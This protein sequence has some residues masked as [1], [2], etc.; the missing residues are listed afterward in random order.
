MLQGNLFLLTCKIITVRLFDTGPAEQLQ[1]RSNHIVYPIRGDERGFT[2]IEVEAKLRSKLRHNFEVRFRVNTALVKAL[3]PPAT[4]LRQGNV[5]TPVYQ[6]FCSQGGVCHPPGHT[7]L[8]T[9][10]ARHPRADTTPQADTPRPDTPPPAKCM[11]GYSQQV[12][13]THPTGMHSCSHVTFLEP[14]K[15]G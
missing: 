1:K 5:F 6:S 12:D 3:F 9:P 8:G 7:P 14:F 11:L 10:L 4:K 2:A 13:G 15:V